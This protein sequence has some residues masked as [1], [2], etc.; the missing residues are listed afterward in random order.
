MQYEKDIQ[1]RDIHILRFICFSVLG[2]CGQRVASYS[3]AWFLAW[4]SAL[5]LLSLSF[6]S[7]S[8]PIAEYEYINIVYAQG[9]D[10][11]QKKYI[12]TIERIKQLQSK[13][14]VRV[15]NRNVRPSAMQSQL[16]SAG[17]Q[18]VIALGPVALN[19]LNAMSHKHKFDIVYG[20]I[21][22]SPSRNSEIFGVSLSPLPET[23]FDQLIALD[24]I[25]K[26]VHV[27]YL[28]NRDEELI[29][30]AK[31]AAL[32]RG[33]VLNAIPTNGISDM[34]I[35]YQALLSDIDATSDA[36]WLLSG[37]DMD[38]VI[39]NAIMA[40]AWK[41]KIF[42]FSSDYNDVNRGVMFSVI[43]N[44]SALGDRLSE[45]LNSLRYKPKQKPF[46]SFT[47]TVRPNFNA[48]TA[49]HL[50]I[51]LPKKLSQNYMILHPAK[52]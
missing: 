13:V 32:S 45:L 21:N 20:F 23:L 52:K 30:E 16:F 11:E 25:R 7:Y 40:Q 17:V 50:G 43:P 51:T 42:V 18:C 10:I 22:E 6:F 35:K 19:T 47:E 12:E 26:N 9:N 14:H 49:K 46:I 4:F 8:Q 36:L 38:S 44:Y 2:C 5:F 31:K 48:L 29:V 37:N 15:I 28:K 3:C 41:K 34:A 1:T 39:I 27:I 33:I 24:N